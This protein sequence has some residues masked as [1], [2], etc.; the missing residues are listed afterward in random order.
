MNEPTII[1]LTKSLI[2]SIKPKEI[3]YAEMAGG[4]AMGNAGGIM[5]YIIKDDALICYKT[6]VFTDEE[7]YVQAEELLLKHQDRFKNA[8]IELQDSLFDHFY[9]GMG[10]NVFVKKNIILEIN[11]LYFIYKKDNM[12]YKILPSVRGVFNSVVYAMK[13]PKSDKRKE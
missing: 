8:N 2:E 13:N 3:I 6:N 4:G 7:T 11:E 10:N 1:Q 12:E 5:L 9:G